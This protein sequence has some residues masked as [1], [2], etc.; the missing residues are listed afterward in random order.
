[1]KK[2]IPI[3]LLCVISLL[4]AKEQI[5]SGEI[6]TEE[7]SGKPQKSVW[8]ALGLSLVLPGAGEIYLGAN[9]K[10]IPLMVADGVILSTATGF[11]IYSHWRKGEYMTFAEKYAGADIDGKDE[12]FFRMLTMYGSRDEYN[13]YVLLTQR[14]RSYLLPETDEWFWLWRS[15]ADQLKYYEIWTSSEHAFN[16][17]KIALAAAGLNRIISAINV[18]RIYRMGPSKWDVSFQ[19][20][21]DGNRKT[22][23]SINFI[24]KF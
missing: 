12:D 3:L 7:E 2:F 22:S 1:M 19:V 13:Y 5:F 24:K 15:D 8:K 18:L 9:G 21:P 11:A 10:G 14:D 23:I 6:L 16:N 4:L 20:S 17:F